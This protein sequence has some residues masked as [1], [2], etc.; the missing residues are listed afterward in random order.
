MRNEK[1]ILVKKKLSEQST[2]INKK[3]RLGQKQKK[4]LFFL[5]EKGEVW[6]GDLYEEFAPVSKYQPFF[7]IRLNRLQRRGLVTTV[8]RY[9]KETKRERK[10]ILL[11][12]AGEQIVKSQLLSQS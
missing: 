1:Y 5:Y 3:I 11:T 8:V 10:Y 4:V 9:C 2:K 12:P 6:I 7:G